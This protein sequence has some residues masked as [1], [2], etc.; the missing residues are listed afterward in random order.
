MAVSAAGSSA[1][2]TISATSVI[3]LTVSALEHFGGHVVQIRL[4]ARRN[5][6]R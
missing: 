6:N 4:V 5:E 1:C 3:G 2:A